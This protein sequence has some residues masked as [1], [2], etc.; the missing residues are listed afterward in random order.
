MELDGRTMVV[1]GGSHGIGAA[2]AE[3]AARRGARVAVA[4]RTTSELEAVATRIGGVALTVDLTDATQVDEF[5]D[6]CVAGLGHVDVFVNNAG[7][8]TAD[9]FVMLDRDAIRR[10]VRL[11][12]EATMILTRDAARHMVRRSSGHL[13]QMSSVAGTTVFPGQSAYV[14]SKAAITNFSESLRLELRGTGVGLTV[15][16]PGPVDT[17][18]WHRIEADDARY[19]RP[20]LRRFRRMFM[21]PTLPIDVVARRTVD[22]IERGR[23]HVRLPRRHAAYHALNHAPRRVVQIGMLGVRLDRPMPPDELDGDEPADVTPGA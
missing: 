8:E 20:A 10:L 7:V 16:A 5:V 12:V 15:V 6:R 4:A 14:G 13:V 17:D 1:T 22:A 18:M 19:P 11:N 2:I 3:E 9:A 23:P 21:L